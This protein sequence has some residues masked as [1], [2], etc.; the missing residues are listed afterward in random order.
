MPKCSRRVTALTLITIKVSE[1][2]LSLQIIND[3]LAAYSKRQCDMVVILSIF[4][5]LFLAKRHFL[6]IALFSLA[7]LPSC[8]KLGMCQSFGF[9]KIAGKKF[10]KSAEALAHSWC[11]VTS[12]NPSCGFCIYRN[13]I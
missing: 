4:V 5:I 6:Y 13:I 12:K 2:L 9:G 8:S 11:L 1:S 7:V 3:L 10:S